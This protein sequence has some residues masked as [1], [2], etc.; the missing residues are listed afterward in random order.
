VLQVAVSRIGGAAGDQTVIESFTAEA[1]E[2]EAALM[3]RAVRG[4][5]RAIEERWKSEQ[6]LQFGREAKL[7]VTVAYDTIGDWVAIQKRLAEL[8]H[9]RRTEIISLSRA[10]AV[11]DIAYLGDENQ[12]RLALAQRDLELTAAPLDP[13]GIPWRLSLGG[14]QKA[15]SRP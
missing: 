11:V 5:V 3:A 7:T 2:E 6:L 12:L 14:A 10:A 1:G 13:S 4:T 8:P 15:R 9:V